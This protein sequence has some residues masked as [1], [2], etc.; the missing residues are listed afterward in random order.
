MENISFIFSNFGRVG[1]IILLI[2]SSYLLWDKPTLFYYY[3]FGFITSAI[4]NII[5]KGI[6]KYPRPSEDPLEFNLALQNGG[7][8]VFKNGIPHDIFGM[9]SGHSQ[10]SMFITTYIFLTLKNK[11]IALIF[12]LLSLLIMYQR[13]KDNHHTLFQVLAGAIVGVGYG[14]LFYYFGQQKLMG[15]IKAKPDDN[16]PL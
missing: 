8:F 13:V 15:K 4:L 10:A 7:R 12:F 9:P 5:L 6:F 3:R 16:G 14:Y 2:I 11:K 1:P